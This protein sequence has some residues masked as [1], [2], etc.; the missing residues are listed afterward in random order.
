MAA[1]TQRSKEFF[2]DEWREQIALMRRNNGDA[3][4][5]H[6]EAM[7]NYLLEGKLP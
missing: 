5:Q 7:K 2:L 6:S 4:S 1:G 3:V